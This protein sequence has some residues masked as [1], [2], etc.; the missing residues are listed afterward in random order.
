[1]KGESIDKTVSLLACGLCQAA[2]YISETNIRKKYHPH[3]QC[4]R[5][6]AKKSTAQHAGAMRK[7]VHRYGVLCYRDWHTMFRALAYYPT[8]VRVVCY[9]RLGRMLRRWH[10]G[11]ETARAVP[12]HTTNRPRVRTK[13]SS[14]ATYTL[15]G[16]ASDVPETVTKPGKESPDVE[17]PTWTAALKSVAAR[18]TAL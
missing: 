17:K 11:Q 5:H 14:A 6:E 9:P 18:P 3:T 12:C 16:R 15:H 1:M 4:R 13:R 10:D 7:C 2:S 8:G